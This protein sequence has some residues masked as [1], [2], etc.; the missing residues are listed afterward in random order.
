MATI[1]VS[2]AY[3]LPEK[4]RVV[5]V[6]IEEGRSLIETVIASG[7]TDSFPEI[8]LT[9]CSIGVFGVKKKHQDPIRPGDRVEIYRRLLADPK[10]VRRQRAMKGQDMKR[11]D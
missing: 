3:A 6:D 4:Q 1:K 5:N 7:I 10:E 11:H 2:V 9:S 8:D